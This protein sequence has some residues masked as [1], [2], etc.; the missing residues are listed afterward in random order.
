MCKARAKALV[1]QSFYQVTG[2]PTPNCISLA[3]HSSAWL[4]GCVSTEE[5]PGSARRGGTP[6]SV[7]Y[8]EQR[9]GEGTSGEGREGE[10]GR[11]AG[12]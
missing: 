12:P 11:E 10:G 5:R 6:A 8:V 4:G 1:S 9:E 7:L 3:S 2:K